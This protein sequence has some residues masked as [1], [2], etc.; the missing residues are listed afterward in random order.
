VLV[1]D[2]IMLQTVR[3]AKS[4]PLLVRPS[5]CSSLCAR[6]SRALT[7]AAPA[8]PEERP[9]QQLRDLQIRIACGGRQRP[10]SAAVTVGGAVPGALERGGAV[11]LG[12]LRINELLVERFGGGG[13]LV[14]DIGEFQLAKE[15]EQGRLVYSHRVF[16][17]FCEWL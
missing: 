9:G 7:G 13:D 3:G 12:R 14:G 16:V 1:S 17:S 8:T 11:E 2:L 15:V 10:W 5:Q 4:P 6:P